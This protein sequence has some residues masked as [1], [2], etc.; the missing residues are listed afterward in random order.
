MLRVRTRIRDLAII[1][2]VLPVHHRSRLPV[3]ASMADPSVVGTLLGYWK[4]SQVAVIVYTGQDTTMSPG[5]SAVCGQ[6]AYVP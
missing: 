3:I 4:A 2:G 6:Y 5:E 1:R